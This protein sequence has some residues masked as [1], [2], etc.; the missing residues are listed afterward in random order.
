MRSSRPFKI[1]VAV[2]LLCG[3]CFCLCGCVDEM[4]AT[5]LGMELVEWE[6]HKAPASFAVFRETEESEP[7]Y[8]QKQA[9]LDYQSA[10][11]DCNSTWYKDQL[12]GD[13]LYIYNCML[14]AMEHC[15]TYFSLYVLDNEKDYWHVRDALALDSPLLEQNVDPDNENCYVWD[16]TPDGEEIA[17]H[18]NHFSKRK[19][20]LK[21]EALAQ[22]RQVVAQMAPE[23]TE[24]EDKMLYLYHYVCDHVEYVDYEN[25]A[26]QDYLYDA[27]CKGETVCD[28]YSNMLSLLF[29]LAGMEACEAMGSD[30]ENDEALSETELSADD[31]GHTWVV[32][33]LDGTFYNFD[34]THE[35][36]LE[37]FDDRQTVYFGFSDRFLS[38]KYTDLDALRPQCMDTSR[39][40]R[41][42]DTTLSDAQDP[43]QIKQLAALT[44]SRIREG[45]SVTYVLITEPVSD[46]QYDRLLDDYIN[47][48]RNIRSINTLLIDYP[49][50]AVIRFTAEPW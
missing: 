18:F 17:F 25:L 46:E 27:T 49:G 11:S 43:A 10:Y 23:L 14:Y 45:Q 20:E 30:I 13:D 41:Y 48:T 7:V 21:M 15:Y 35:D 36:T 4:T 38:V 39:D 24:Q 47:K 28:G 6:Y 42:V 12:A 8:I 29:N 34:P 3:L 32:A 26:G 16:P 50:C 22:C 33:K 9:I 44:D 40:F 37:N 1:L 5:L 2:C 31:S 19:W